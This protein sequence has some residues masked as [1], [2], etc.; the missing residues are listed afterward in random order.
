MHLLKFDMLN[1][2]DFLLQS[3][4][5][6]LQNQKK[7][8]THMVNNQYNNLLYTHHKKYILAHPH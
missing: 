5:K 8:N 1:F 4:Y 6:A 7:D 2:L 3:F